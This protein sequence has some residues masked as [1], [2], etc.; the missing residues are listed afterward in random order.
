MDKSRWKS[1]RVEVRGRLIDHLSRKVFDLHAWTL[2]DGSVR[3]WLCLPPPRC[4]QNNR[5]FHK[6]HRHL[7]RCFGGIFGYWNAP[8]GLIVNLNDALSVY[9]SFADNDDLF[10]DICRIRK[11]RRI[12]DT[13]KYVMFANECNGDFFVYQSLTGRVALVGFDTGRP[14]IIPWKGYGDLLYKFEGIPNFRAWVEALA[15]ERLQ[16]VRDGSGG[17]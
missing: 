8:G 7:S 5:I 17:V 9:S 14:G 15:N 10:R 3:G 4:R 11:K 12:I 13:S 2:N 16:N 6:D 1:E